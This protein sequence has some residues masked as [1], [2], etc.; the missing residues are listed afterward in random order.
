LRRNQ[1]LKRYAKGSF[2]YR[3]IKNALIYIKNLEKE[4]IIAFNK[5][6]AKEIRESKLKFGASGILVKGLYANKAFPGF[7]NKPAKWEEVTVAFLAAKAKAKKK[8]KEEEEVALTML[9]SKRKKT[10]QTNVTN[11]Q[12]GKKDL[13][14]IGNTPP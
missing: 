1:G 8:D 13:K 2:I 12:N 4:G 3:D 14:D 11:K 7:A 5:L 6:K 10:Q 9:I